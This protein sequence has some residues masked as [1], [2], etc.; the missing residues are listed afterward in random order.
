MRKLIVLVALVAAIVVPGS[1]LAGTGVPAPSVA[2]GGQSCSGGG[3]GSSGCWSQLWWSNRGLP[4]LSSI[5][6]YVIVNWC[7]SFGRITSFSIG[8][9]G[10]D[11]SGFV[12]CQPAEAFLTSGGVGQGYA[13]FEAHAN[14]GL[15]LPKALGYNLTDIVY[16]SIAP[17]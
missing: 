11:T 1:A 13:T 4:Y 16:G 8:T 3:V 17:G 14:Y 15:T 10:C 5:H 12:V 7:K 9:H 2:C 6:H